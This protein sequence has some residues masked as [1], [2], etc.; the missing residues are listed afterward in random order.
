LVFLIELVPLVET[1][2]V[3][4]EEL[5]LV[6]VRLFTIVFELTPDNVDDLVFNDDLEGVE[7]TVF[8][9]EFETD[10]ETVL[11]PVDVFEVVIEDVL[12]IVNF[13]DLVLIEVADIE[14]ELDEVFEDFI[15][16]V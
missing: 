8:V 14:A 6:F 11:E 3:L 2:E 1:V 5:D 9:L 13:A 12:V 7:V 15:D 16:A 10:F 4:L